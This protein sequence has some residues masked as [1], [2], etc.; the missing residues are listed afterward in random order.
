MPRSE[1]IVG[2]DIGTTKVCTVIGEVAE[3]G[4]VDIIGVG[5]SPSRGLSKGVVTNIDNTVRSIENSVAEAEHMAGVRIESVYVGI[6][7]G[8]ISSLN[9]RGIIAVSRNN[10][11]ITEDD[12]RRAIE[13][14]K[15][16]A[17]PPDR[18]VIHVIPREF[19]IDGQGGIQDPVG[20][21]G[22]RLEVEVHIV[23]GS[24]PA[25]QNI[26]NC[27]RKVGLEVEDLVLQPLACS[28]AIITSPEKELGVVL[29][30][31]G[32]GTTD[33]AIFLGGSIWHS[34]II[35][36]GGDHVTSDIAYGLRT[37]RV[38]AEK[39]KKLYG[40]ALVSMVDNE[41]MIEVPYVGGEKSRPLPNRVLCE[42][43]EPRMDEIFRMVQEEI[44]KS[45]YTGLIPIPGGLVLTGGCSLMKGVAELASQR[46]NL[47]ARIGKPENICGLVDIA[48]NPIYST[49]VGLVQYGVLNRHRQGGRTKRKGFSITGLFQRFGRW[50]RNFF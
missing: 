18:E 12:K 44:K 29:I 27:V 42:I 35:P 28:E 5:I 20:M 41:Q 1:M 48:S 23:T 26:E 33:I 36:I 37:P 2:L 30:D 6:A 8:H 49:A 47:T 16:M 14:A 24:I 15:A 3:D 4:L 11:T 7:G 17:I 21:A 46:L 39:L 32:G 50:L 31:I 40:S 34:A 22:I 13:A 10:P 43:I 38:E 19:I 9:S 25:V 45:G